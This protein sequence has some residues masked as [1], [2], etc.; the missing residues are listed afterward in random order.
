MSK[1]LDRSFVLSQVRKTNVS[2]GAGSL[3]GFVEAMEKIDQKYPVADHVK[4]RTQSSE[5]RK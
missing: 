4:R 2:Q 5:K 3:M 1:V